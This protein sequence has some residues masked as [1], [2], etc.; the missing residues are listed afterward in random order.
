M[1][2]TNDCT[3]LIPGDRT[4]PSGYPGGPVVPPGQVSPKL[5]RRSDNVIHRP[6]AGQ[7]SGQLSGQPASSG[8]LSFTRALEMTDSIAGI[9]QRGG[10][11][12]GVA[13]GREGEEQRES[14]YDMNYEIS[15]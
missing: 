6:A 7:L 11:A 15:V 10:V 1:T 14:V 12:N 8:P 9:Q 3:I 4:T 13:G 5:G 2:P